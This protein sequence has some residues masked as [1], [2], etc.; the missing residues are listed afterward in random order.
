MTIPHLD[1]QQFKL[2]IQ[3]NA[4]SQ[5]LDASIIQDLELVQLLQNDDQKN[6]QNDD[7]DESNDK[8]KDETKD[9]PLYEHVFSPT[10]NIGK[11]IMGEIASYTTSDQTYLTEFQSLLQNRVDK[12]KNLTGATKNKKRKEKDGAAKDQTK[13]N[14]LLIQMLE[15]WSQIKGETS[16]CEKYS[17]IQWDFAK[18]LNANPLFMQ[19]MSIYNIASPIISLCSPLLILLIP[20]FVLKMKQIPITVGEYGNIL[21][22][23]MASNPVAKVFTGFS[24]LGSG[25]K[26][27]AIVSASFYLFTIYQ[28]VLSCVRFYNNMRDIHGHLRCMQEYAEYSLAQMRDFSDRIKSF[29]SFADF[30]KNLDERIIEFHAWKLELMDIS[31]FTFSFSKIKQ[32]G[33][34]LSHFY[35]IHASDHI[36]KLV[37]YSFGF[38]GYMENMAGLTKQLDDGAMHLAKFEKLSVKLNKK[39]KNKFRGLFYP[40]FLNNENESNTVITNDCSLAKN[41]VITAPNGGGKTTMLKSVMINTLLC[42]QVG[43]GCFERASLPTL[44]SHFHCYLNIPD[45]SGRDSLF[46]AEARRCKVILDS[47]SESES[48]KG[49]CAVEKHLCIFDEL[50]SGTNPEEAV[51]SATSFMQ[52]LTQKPQVTCMLTTHYT[53]LCSNLEA[54]KR[55]VNMHMGIKR[56]ATDKDQF[57]YTYKLAK[58]ISTVKGGLKVLKDM[59]YPAEMLSS[60]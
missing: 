41:I 9:K 1:L 30:K 33:Q 55:V 48:I 4:K 59:D 26:M 17:Y 13:P 60:N 53:Q 47:I 27:Y 38:H 31:G 24:E 7:Q 29:V 22:G 16:F 52:Y 35:T 46:Q 36:A 40:K 20:F 49:G 50:Y 57:Q 19:L 11:N 28:N 14:A 42:Q 37:S 54:N 21:K 44:F 25:Q 15:T 43:A 2:P 6:D 45:T 12:D 51:E 34:V 23:L 56:N 5:K 3:Y 8:N 39:K 58:G 10:T 32:F 18:G